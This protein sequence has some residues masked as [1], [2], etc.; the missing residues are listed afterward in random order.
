MGVLVQS[1]TCLSSTTIQ[2]V[3]VKVEVEMEVEMEVVSNVE[4]FQ[5]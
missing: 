3:T 4:V 1:T 5:T 2:P